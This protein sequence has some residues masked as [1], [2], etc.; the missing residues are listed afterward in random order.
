MRT[1]CAEVYLR[2]CCTFNS[3]IILGKMKSMI[4]FLGLMIS[5]VIGADDNNAVIFPDNDIFPKFVSKGEIIVLN[6]VGSKVELPCLF[7][8]ERKKCFFLSQLR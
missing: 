6:D 5:T 8:S 7:E 1:F 2:I 3:I 4:S